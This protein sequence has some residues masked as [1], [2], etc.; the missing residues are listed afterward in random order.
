MAHLAV[1]PQVQDGN[2]Q[3]HVGAH[4]EP[5][6]QVPQGWFSLEAWTH[7]IQA[8]FASLGE[9]LLPEILE[10]RITIMP[11]LA[12][13][14]TFETFRAFVNNGL[15][16][17]QDLAERSITQLGVDNPQGLETEL[18]RMGGILKMVSEAGDWIAAHKSE[19]SGK[20]IEAVQINQ[21]LLRSQSLV[22]QL[23]QRLPDTGD[24]LQPAPQHWIPKALVSPGSRNQGNDCF[25]NSA[26]QGIF[27]DP[28]A[29]KWIALNKHQH[30]R[31]K[32]KAFEYRQACLL[33]QATPITMAQNIRS[34]FPEIA[35]TAQHEVHRA[36]NYFVFA[37]TGTD[38]GVVQK[39][40]YFK[41]RREYDA[42]NPFV[43]KVIRRATY[44]GVEMDQVE[45]GDKKKFQGNVHVSELFDWCPIL[46][47][48]GDLG[49]R[50][51]ESLLDNYLRP[52]G[53]HTMQFN[54]HMKDGQTNPDVAAT[55]EVAQFEKRPE[56]IFLSFKRHNWTKERG[57][58]RSS[59][60]VELNET[61]YLDPKHVA[62][63]EGGEYE[64]RYFACH[65][66]GIS[67]SGTS[68]HYWCYRKIDGEWHYY[69]D[70]SHRKATTQE[71][72]KDLREKCELLLAGRVDKPMSQEEVTAKVKEN[73][74][75]AKAAQLER[76]IASAKT[77]LPKGDSI[78]IKEQHLARVKLFRDFLNKEEQPKPQLLVEI[79]NGTPPEFQAFCQQMLILEG[80]MEESDD[81][82]AHLL[83]LKTIMTQYLTT[84]LGEHIVA[85]YH[86][87]R[88]RQLEMI[89]AELEAQTI[90]GDFL[91]HVK[92]SQAESI[93][94]QGSIT[95][96]EFNLAATNTLLARLADTNEP[97]VLAMGE[98]LI[99]GLGKYIEAR[100]KVAAEEEAPT[101]EEILTE[102]RAFNT[103]FILNLQRQQ[104][105]NAQLSA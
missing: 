21:T 47:L 5:A 9:L 91:R 97:D 19:F 96:T 65:G 64:I 56:H 74:E 87:V 72:Q 14:A 85:Q 98:I 88:Q 70:T 73:V 78:D 29:Y 13:N 53:K 37:M 3:H 90:K 48:E 60:P 92:H 104:T 67:S 102:L 100:Q 25:M 94:L 17:Q 50:A 2:K 18:S 55:E 71:V 54:F 33:G 59:A 28:L 57:S 6:G 83:D 82:H 44:G 30:D 27:G 46:S 22:G 51:I 31:I 84:E 58:F 79:F 43:H 35:G 99:P 61:F 26:L 7:W 10:D 4:L 75:A 24:L 11:S 93:S 23:L 80:K 86:Y 52:S 12:K 1:H 95:R 16:T 103:Q 8:F 77:P 39:D 49:S 62:S 32:L 68:G 41:D 105:I 15:D 45:E 81:V 42:G 89:R 101:L 38:E 76:E 69:S 34:L 36:F 20:G 40:D 66:G 63:S